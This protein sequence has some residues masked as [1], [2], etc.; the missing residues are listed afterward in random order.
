MQIGLKLPVLLATNKDSFRKPETGMWS[1]F[2]EHGNG[3][4]EPGMQLPLLPCLALT[5]GYGDV[6]DTSI[7]MQTR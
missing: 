3:G 7:L 1:H 6:T 5:R 2:V 4:T